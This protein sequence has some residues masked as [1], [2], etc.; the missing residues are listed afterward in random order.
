MPSFK[1]TILG[2]AGSM[3]MILGPAIVLLGSIFLAVAI[4]WVFFA[5]ILLVPVTMAIGEKIMEK[6]YNL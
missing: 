3:F 5:G 2:Y 6:G 4:H 1:G